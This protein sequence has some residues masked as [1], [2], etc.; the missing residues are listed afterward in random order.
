MTIRIL[1]RAPR[2][3]DP[4]PNAR[5]SDLSRALLHEC[6]TTIRLTGSSP[7][8]P[9]LARF[10]LSG[11]SDVRMT[12]SDIDALVLRAVRSSVDDAADFLTM[13]EGPRAD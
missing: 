8:G 5:M 13:L 4:W 9:W 10:P 7:N 3:V 1:P 2:G 6:P 11:Q 12:G